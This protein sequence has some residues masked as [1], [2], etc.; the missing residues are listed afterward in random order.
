MAFLV[1][2]GTGLTLIGLV[3]LV[4]SMIAVL[5]ARRA[6]IDDAAL[7]ARLQRIVAVNF[8]GLAVS[9]LGLMM[10]VMGMALG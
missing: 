5:R 7:K 8:A 4:G 1:P 10:V 9:A 2:L 6:G 3:I